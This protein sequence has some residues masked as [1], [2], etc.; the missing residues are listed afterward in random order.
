[1]KCFFGKNSTITQTL[2][3]ELCLYFCF[4]L[5]I[6]IFNEN[7]SITNHASKIRRPNFS[8][9]VIN[10]ANCND[11][12][13]YIHDF[14]DIAMFFLSNLVAGPSFM[15][16]SLLT[17]VMAIFFSKKL[18]RHLKMGNTLACV[19]PNI[20]KLGQCQDTTFCTNATN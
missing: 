3:Q 10:Y 4:Q 18:T 6:V 19:L 16:I 15:S 20:W 17:R 7:V 5:S 13:I 14:F 1:M 9:L 8:K 11:V 12:T 2:V